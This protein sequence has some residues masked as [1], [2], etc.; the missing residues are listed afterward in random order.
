MAR[1]IV[2]GQNNSRIVASPRDKTQVII[3]SGGIGPAGPAGP[4]GSAEGATWSREGDPIT[5]THGGVAAGS[6]LANGLNAIEIL[7]LILYPYQSVSF[8]SFNDSL[9]TYYELGQP[10]GNSTEFFTW[11]TS[12]PDSNWVD[13]SISISSSETGTILSGLNYNDT[14]T[15]YNHPQYI[16]NTV[17][18]IT[19]TI[20]GQ[21]SEGS[22]PTASTSIQW[23]H[24]GYYGRAGT[25]GSPVTYTDLADLSGLTKVHPFTSVDNWSVSIASDSPPSYIYFVYPEDI[26][27]GTPTVTD[28]TNPNTPLSVPITMGSRFIH[29]NDYGANVYYNYF[30]TTNAIG[31][32]VNL[33]VDT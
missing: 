23:R 14:P 25:D 4:A 27:S 28:I 15:P 5:E 12:G 8:S 22:N 2:T 31:G 10:A 3:T 13:G 6:T 30:R 33:R 21:Q 7:E 16:K 29:R 19:F 32:A 9:S 20:S 1:I 11:T 24:A 18:T 17:S 26:Y